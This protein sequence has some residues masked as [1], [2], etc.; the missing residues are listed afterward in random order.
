MQIFHPSF[1]RHKRTGI[2][3]PMLQKR[4]HSL[5]IQYKPEG[6]LWICSLNKMVIN[7]DPATYTV[8]ELN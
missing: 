8:D 2:L 4:E 6:N 3:G 1:F 7:F 5:L